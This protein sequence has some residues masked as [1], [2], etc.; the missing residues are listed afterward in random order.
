MIGGRNKVV[1]ATDD[2]AQRAVQ[3]LA[4][5]AE[6]VSALT[7]ANGAQANYAALSFM[8]VLGMMRFEDDGA[9]D[10]DYAHELL[11]EQSAG[12]LAAAKTA[13]A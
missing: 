2:A 8:A 5:W 9:A 3:R 11:L 7:G 13:G 12:L 1:T 4:E 10:L 6:D